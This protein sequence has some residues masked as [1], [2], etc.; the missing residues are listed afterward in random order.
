MAAMCLSWLSLGVCGKR[1][2]N[3]GEALVMSAGRAA[4]TW[5]RKDMKG[6]TAVHKVQ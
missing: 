4:G 6:F 1:G 2:Q 3:E 5:R